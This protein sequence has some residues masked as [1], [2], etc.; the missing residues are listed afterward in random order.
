MLSAV[1]VNIPESMQRVKWKRT[2]EKGKGTEGKFEVCDLCFEFWGEHVCHPA[3]K[4]KN[5]ERPLGGTRSVDQ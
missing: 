2:G 5:L 4:L 3:K 1:M